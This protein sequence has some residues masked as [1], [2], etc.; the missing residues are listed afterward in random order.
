MKIDIKESIIKK[1]V[2]EISNLIKMQIEKG[3]QVF[4]AIDNAL[5]EFELED[6]IMIKYE[7]E[8][9]KRGNTKNLDIKP[10]QID[11]LKDEIIKLVYNK[12]L[13]KTD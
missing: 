7:V 12:Y 4:Q 11:K 10:A 2:N 1:C 5:Q 8:M 6:E 3:I 13:N 9:V